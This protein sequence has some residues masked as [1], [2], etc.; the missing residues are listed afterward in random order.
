MK[1][2][3]VIMLISIYLVIAVVVPILITM[4]LQ[5]RYKGR[6]TGNGAI[7]FMLF[8]IVYYGLFFTQ[9]PKYTRPYAAKHQYTEMVCKPQTFW[10]E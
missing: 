5:R 8:L 1:P 6:L 7:A 9:V 10:K 4:Y 3:T 2:E